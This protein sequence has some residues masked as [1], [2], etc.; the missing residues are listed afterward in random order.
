MALTDMEPH[1]VAGTSAA[2]GDRRETNALTGRTKALA[3]SIVEPNRIVGPL[4]NAEAT[5]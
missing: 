2:A 3:S 4:S 5:K 1:R